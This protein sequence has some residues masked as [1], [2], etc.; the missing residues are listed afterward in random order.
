MTLETRVSIRIYR[1]SSLKFG[2]SFVVVIG[3]AFLKQYM[4]KI[5]FIISLSIIVQDVF[6]VSVNLKLVL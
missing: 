6:L 4:S 3:L 5:Y 1:E 2:I